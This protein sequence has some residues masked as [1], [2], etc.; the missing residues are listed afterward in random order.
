MK[1][2]FFVFTSTNIYKNCTFIFQFSVTP[3]FELQLVAFKHH[4]KEHEKYYKMNSKLV[5]SVV[6]IFCSNHVKNAPYKKFYVPEPE[7]FDKKF[8]TGFREKQEIKKSL[9]YNNFE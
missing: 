8:T 5:F 3:L 1:K 2:V 7:H 9:F 6:H 4:L